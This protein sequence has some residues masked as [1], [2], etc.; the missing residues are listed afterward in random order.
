M[1]VGL[2]PQALN[3]EWTDGSCC[4]VGSSIGQGEGVFDPLDVPFWPCN[5]HHIEPA[6][7]LRVGATVGQ[8]MMG[9]LDEIALFS[10]THA[11]RGSA[12]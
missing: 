10:V 8:I 6:R 1:C 5:G 2:A 12:K 3:D 11:A 4:Y 7:G 9:S